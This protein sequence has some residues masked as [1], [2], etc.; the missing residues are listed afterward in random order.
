MICWVTMPHRQSFHNSF[1][2]GCNPGIFH[3]QVFIRNKWI[4]DKTCLWG[5]TKNRPR[6]HKG[7]EKLSGE[8]A[9]FIL[10]NASNLETRKRNSDFTTYLCAYWHLFWQST[11]GALNHRA[12]CQIKFSVHVY[13][14]IVK[15]ICERAW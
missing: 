4:F 2:F 8:I 1:C 15:G 7:T 12:S 13:P 3:L 5:E 9:H 10:I 14:H 11:H 6:K